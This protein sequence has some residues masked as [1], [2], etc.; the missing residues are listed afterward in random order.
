M[1]VAIT[2]ALCVAP[3]L[4]LADVAQVRE[5]GRQAPAAGR[6]EQLLNFFEH[7]DVPTR[8]EAAKYMGVFT[9][10]GGPDETLRNRAMA[11]ALEGVRTGDAKMQAS[12]LVSFLGIGPDSPLPKPGYGPGECG[13]SP[14]IE[15]PRQNAEFHSR[16]PQVVGDRQA[17]RQFLGKVSTGEFF[18]IAR[19]YS[20]DPDV[21]KF[22]ARK[23]IPKSASLEADL[24]RQMLLELGPDA[25]DAELI[26]PFFSRAFAIESA[27]IAFKIHKSLLDRFFGSGEHRPID[28][29]FQMGNVPPE[30]AR[31]LSFSPNP[32]VAIIGYL[33]SRPTVIE[34]LGQ[35]PVLCRSIPPGPLPIMK[36]VPVGVVQRNVDRMSAEFARR[37]LAAR[38][39]SED[40]DQL[41]RI[42]APV[43]S[44]IN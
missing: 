12:I 11:L 31:E 40:Y 15:F 25:K 10:F 17:W 19:G 22:E 14:E 33:M 44:R 32:N 18:R 34:S 38:A 23:R 7:G 42:L 9:V 43:L 24:C 37:L 30:K 16:L 39:A 21:A 35:F 29:R 20:R 2:L 6:L 1:R 4:G 26:R 41:A 5:I 13:N 36:F 8:R 3:I 27:S 28:L